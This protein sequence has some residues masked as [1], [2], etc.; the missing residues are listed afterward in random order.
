MSVRIYLKYTRMC[1]CVCVCVRAGALSVVCLHCVRV[2]RVNSSERL[3][4]LTDRVVSPAT[5]RLF[6]PRACVGLAMPVRSYTCLWCTGLCIRGRRKAS[7]DKSYR[8]NGLSDCRDDRERG[9]DTER[10]R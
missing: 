8:E 7:T 4:G 5:R 2:S 9:R 3:T 1:V 10:G 6:I